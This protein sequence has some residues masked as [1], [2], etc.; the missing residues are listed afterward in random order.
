MLLQGVLSA[1]QKLFNGSARVRLFS[2]A[3]KLHFSAAT[4]P[5]ASDAAQCTP[6]VV[7]KDDASLGQ[8]S[9]V[10][11]GMPALETIRTT[12]IVRTSWRFA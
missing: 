4:V 9:C 8:G 1:G 2:G 10:K 5:D 7:V 12:S 6:L 11:K 3:Y